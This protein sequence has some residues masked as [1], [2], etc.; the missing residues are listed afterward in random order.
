[1]FENIRNVWARTPKTVK[2]FFYLAL[3]TFLAELLI[4]FR[5]MEQVFIVRFLAQVINLGIVF[6]QEAIPEARRRLIG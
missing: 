6:L 3:S 4:E 2:V 5:G 1:V